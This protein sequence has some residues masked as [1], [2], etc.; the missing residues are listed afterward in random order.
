MEEKKTVFDYIAGGL[1]VYGVMVTVFVLLSLILGDYVGDYSSLFRYGADGLSV[2]TLLQL[3]LLAAM[4]TLARIVFLTGRWI[5]NMSGLLRNALF[6]LTI[7]AVIAV[8]IVLFGWFPIN[9]PRAWLGFILS[10]TVSMVLSVVVTGLRERAENKRM[11]A[12]LRK[13]KTQ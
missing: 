12:A 1:A 3:L 4:I 11:Q 6:F 8:L 2:P 5:K 7:L 13:Y 9:E 10:Y